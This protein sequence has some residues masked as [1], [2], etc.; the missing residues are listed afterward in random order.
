MKA[1]IAEIFKSIQGEGLYVGCLQTFIRFYGCNLHCAYCDTP[2]THYTE[3]TAEELFEKLL[4]YK[5]PFVSLTGGE[6]L[7]QTAFLRE[8]LPRAKKREFRVFLETNGTLPVQ[9]KKII[10]WIDIISCD[11]KLKSSTKERALWGVHEK[12]F[13]VSRK[14][15]LFFKAVITPHTEFGDIQRTA[16][17]M[18]NKK[19][20]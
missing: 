14:K 1:K 7:L 19:R 12:F 20:H 11:I 16:Q 8:F 10:T 18:K 17:F 3:Y 15:E 5:I 9:L 6:P 13:S 2:L 4:V